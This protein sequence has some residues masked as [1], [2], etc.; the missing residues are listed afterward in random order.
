MV[1]QEEVREMVWVEESSA[2]VVLGSGVSV[3]LRGED[4]LSEVLSLSGPPFG[5]L[6][7]GGV[8][9]LSGFKE[10]SWLCDSV[11]RNK[12]IVSDIN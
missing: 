6:A 11:E 4:G 8:L 5:G 9:G 2:V 3:G 10:L 7:L 1:E 12:E